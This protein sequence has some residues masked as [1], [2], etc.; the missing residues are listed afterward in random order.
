[1]PIVVVYLGGRPLWMNPQINQSSSFV[2]AWLPGT[3]GGGVAD[4]LF[5][6]SQINGRLSVNWPAYDCTG[7]PS[8][9]SNALFPVGYGLTF[10]DTLQISDNLPSTPSAIW[11]T[12]NFAPGCVISN[13]IFSPLD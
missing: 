2:V 8:E 11:G 9:T 6:E 12:L 10:N 5:G 13:I 3:E 7:S 1:M 4:G